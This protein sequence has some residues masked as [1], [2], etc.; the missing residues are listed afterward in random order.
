MDAHLWAVILA[1]GGGTRFWPLSRRRRPKQFLAVLGEETLLQTTWRRAVAVAGATGR[2]LLVTAEAYADVTGQQV[3]EL[4]EENLLL[5]PRGR[6]TAPCVA[7]AA[8]SLVRRDPEAVMVVL[9]ADHFIRDVEGFIRGVERAAAAARQHGTLTTFGVPPRYPETGYGYL[10]VGEELAVEAGPGEVPVYRVAAFREKPD[11]ATAEE[12][13]GAGSFLWNSGIFVWTVA[14]ILEALDRH[15]PAARRA[16]EAMAEAAGA[17]ARRA[18]YAEMPATSIDYGVMERADNVACVRAPFDWSDVGSWAAL[19]ELLPA[20]REGNAVQ[21]GAVV[22]QDARG[23]LIHCPDK[24]VA[25]LDVEDLVVV[26]AGD[27]LLVTSVERSQ[28]IPQL[29]ERLRDEGFEDLL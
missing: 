20:D 7:W 18:A 26:D 11:A 19:R 21:G 3:P 9:P 29:R 1:G 28:Q 23:N 5:E 24:L 8:A 4:Q 13:V 12:Y 25:L 10:E 2:V 14:A 16:A 22:A 17:A 15:L 27:V 6:N